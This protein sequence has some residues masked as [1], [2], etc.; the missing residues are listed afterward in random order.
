MAIDTAKERRSVA[1]ILL[2]WGVTPN[3]SKDS[4]WRTQVGGS[5]TPSAAVSTSE[6]RREAA[7]VLLGPGVTPNSS[8]D[9]E[10]RRQVAWCI[11]PRSQSGTI[12]KPQFAINSNVVIQA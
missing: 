3:A 8:K 2:G 10:W 4:A 6:W 1:G 9:A 12:F 5:V 7:H 11:T